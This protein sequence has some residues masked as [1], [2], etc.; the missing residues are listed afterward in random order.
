MWNNQFGGGFG[1]MMRSV[2]GD[3]NMGI[4]GGAG[5]GMQPDRPWQGNPIGRPPTVGV[6][7][8]SQPQSGQFLPGFNKGEGWGDITG[9]QWGMMI[10]NTLGG[11]G[12]SYMNQRNFDRQFEES[13]RRYEEEQEREKR[14]WQAFANSWN[15]A[16]GGG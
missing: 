6:P 8:T 16:A 5:I 7:A 1:G 13:Q 2:A 10:A 12:S 14:R 11:L 9:P 15:T 3:P 4:F